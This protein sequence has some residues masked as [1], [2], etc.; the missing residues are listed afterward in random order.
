MS[1]EQPITLYESD[2]IELTDMIFKRF[3]INHSGAIEGNEIAGMISDI[4]RLEKA[5]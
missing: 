3:D 4:Y 5:R 2:V 1:L